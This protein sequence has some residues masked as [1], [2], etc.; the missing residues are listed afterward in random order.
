MRVKN[1]T[2]ILII[3]VTFLLQASTYCAPEKKHSSHKEEIE[4]LLSKASSPK[5]SHGAKEIFV[6][7]P[8]LPPPENVSDVGDRPDEP[9]ISDILEEDKE[10]LAIRP[11]FEN[12][13]LENF[14]NFVAQ[15]SKINVIPTKDT[16]GVK[17]SLNMRT[18]LSK[19]DV[20]E[21]FLTVI[22]MAGFTINKAG[23]AYRVLRQDAKRTEPLPAY[24]NV[25][26]H[27]LPDSDQSI[28]FVTFLRNIQASEVEGLLKG[29]LGPGGDIVRQDNVNGYV[30]TDK[31]HN[32]KAAMTI[33]NELDNTGLR[34]EVAV[35]PLKKN[36]ASDVKKLLE[37]MTKS[38]GDRNNNA[39]V[40]RLLG[41]TQES[42][43]YFSATTK[44]IA[45]D[46]SNSLILLG[47]QKS[48]KKIE[49]FIAKYIEREEPQVDSPIHRYQLEYSD[50]QTMKTLLDDIVNSQTDSGTEKFGG[51]RMGGKYFK[52]MRFEVDKESNS[53][54]VSCIDKKDW[55]MLKQTIKQLDTPQPQVV[56]ETLVVD[57]DLQDGK[58]LGGQMRMPK[59]DQPFSNIGWQAAAMAPIVT[60]G[61][62][63]SKTLAGDLS[64]ILNNLT[65]GSASFAISKVSGGAWALFNIVNQNF[66]TS[67]VDNSFMT[68]ANR[69][70]STFSVGESR[71]I[72]SAVYSGQTGNSNS[73]ETKPVATSYTY[74][75]QI[76]S[77]GLVNLSI[78]ISLNEFTV[79]S[80]GGDTTN[81]TLKTTLA[82]ADGQVLVLGGYAKTK[83]TEG[84]TDGMPILSSI[85]ILGWLLKYKTRKVSK[86]YTFF[87]ICPTVVKPR[88]SQG[89]DPYTRMKLHRARK[90]VAD[91]VLTSVTQD[92]IHDL[93]FNPN[94]ES[95]FHKVDD[96]ASA[97]F[98]PSTV[99]LAHDPYY[100]PG[101]KDKN[102]LDF[103]DE[104]ENDLVVRRMT[105]SNEKAEKSSKKD[106][107]TKTEATKAFSRKKSSSP[108]KKKTILSEISSEMAEHPAPK[109]PN[110]II[111]PKESLD[112]EIQF[113]TYSSEKR[114]RLKELLANPDSQTSQAESLSSQRSAIKKLI[115][116]PASSQI[117]PESLA[118]APERTI[119]NAIPIK[120]AE[121]Q[122]LISQQQDRREKLKQ[123]LS[124]GDKTQEQHLAP[125]TNH[126]N[127]LK[128]LL[129]SYDQPKNEVA[130]AKNDAV[131]NQIKGVR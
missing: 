52:K 61:E 78:D 116:P 93:F 87:F 128:K 44:I 69:V 83:I 36:D 104:Y 94:K 51:V 100:N 43:E 60:A 42:T 119:I 33:I 117:L 41:K 92:P 86:V 81:K 49:E 115:E 77:D 45:E 80:G 126:R 17:V 56:I 97:R 121:I 118:K 27:T 114:S 15:L 38:A 123:T 65:L 109:I 9:S 26:A 63:S 120:T 53:L 101:I 79:G 89:I 73:Y 90:D 75:P 111:M 91:S 112:R 54:L 88:S 16:Q 58:E 50:A 96:F 110:D 19:K 76:N 29:M 24:I 127:N 59:S 30:L 40:A 55:K 131:V 12:A 74:T 32:I 68:I 64:S 34:E 22:E 102:R 71:R 72:I 108:S 37:E 4:E 1:V 106:V 28:R 25:P 35:I 129:A 18:D 66:N 47:N 6:Y 124:F 95:Y 3:L 20:W 23:N 85:P 8:N 39:I 2:K 99:D 113:P 84:F 46:R 82:C 5:K 10:E 125:I 98:Q 48:I 105:E 62:T 11:N 14:I 7:N 107:E 31:C 122:E 103:Q 13:D 70:S 67:L 130:I 21:V 57:I